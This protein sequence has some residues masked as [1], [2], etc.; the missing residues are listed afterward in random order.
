MLGTIFIYI[1]N[2][3]LVLITIS[4]LYISVKPASSSVVNPSLSSFVKPAF[5]VLVLGFF[6][7]I[8]LC[9]TFKSP[10]TTTGFLASSSETYFLNTRMTTSIS[11]EEQKVKEWTNRQSELYSR[12]SVLITIKKRYNTY[13]CKLP[14]KP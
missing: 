2:E 8:S 6:R 5:L 10:H 7:S 12:C 4:Y 9:A 13:L 1:R 14:R 3:I 11:S